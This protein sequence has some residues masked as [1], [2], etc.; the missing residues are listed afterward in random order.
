MFVHRLIN[1]LVTVLRD[2]AKGIMTLARV[3]R[4]FLGISRCDTVP[5]FG[6]AESPA[7]CTCHS[8][9]LTVMARTRVCKNITEPAT[10]LL[11]E[12]SGVSPLQKQILQK[13]HMWYKK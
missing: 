7:R 6:I 5:G 11:D 4:T 2:N 10:C 12:P 3:R 9:A 1:R 13:R 8:E